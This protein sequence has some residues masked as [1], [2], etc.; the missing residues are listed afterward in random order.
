MTSILV[1]DDERSMRD[2]LKILLAKEGYAVETAA[3]GDEALQLLNKQIFHLVIT[4]I[5]MDRMSGLEL[6]NAI[7][8]HN[9]A[10]PVVMIT[11]FASPDD[12]VFAMKNGAFDYIS[13][14][15]NV[16]EIKSVIISATSKTSELAEAKSISAHFPE[17]IGESREMIKIFEMIQRIAPTPASV[18]IYGESGTGKEL[19]AQ[20]IHRH[21]Q[22]AEQEF[23][24]ITC[25]AI[26]EEL[27]ESELF[28]HV[29]GSFTGAISDKQGLF[30]LADR[31][32]AFLD[33]IG[34][35]TP[36]IQTKLLRV[37]QEREVKPVG[38]TKIQ[39]V[40]VR[41]IAATNKILE[42]EIIAG[43]FREDLYYRLAVVPLRVP[44]LRE[45][46]GD[47]PL[48]VDYF[49]K[50]YSTLFGKEV[51]EIS[52]YAMEVLMKYDFPGNVRELENIIERG[53]ALETS[54]IIL[55]ESLTLSSFRSDKMAEERHKMSPFQIV[56]NEDELFE[57]GLEEVMA[58]TEK[59]FL[60]TALKTSGNSKMQAAEL[61]RISFRSFRYK[62][63]KYELG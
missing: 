33:E 51:Q 61:L 8:E 47:V 4:D 21:S 22:V 17:I 29:K 39:H 50:K 37:L 10:L 32:T 14:P 58:E 11:A 62:V 43:R 52:S 31:G 48:L 15:F 18:L 26:P 63:K 7:K 28:G 30:Q 55:P 49:L 2:F 3:N 27:M 6:L 54:N 45:R 41:I 44:P 38:G 9:P 59:T 57:R 34:E 25:S 53:V 36:I 5:K 16:D 1:V 20:A 12:A 46:K 42:E 23:V 24:P 13:K 35:L 56:A 19:V 60:N 40:S